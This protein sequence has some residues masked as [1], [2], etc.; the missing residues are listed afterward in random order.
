VYVGN[1]AMPAGGATGYFVELTF[2]SNH[3]SPVPLPFLSDPFVFTTEV[4]VKSPLP[5]HEWPFE[6]AFD[7]LSLG[8]AFAVAGSSAK[9]AATASALN[10][11]ASALA[12]EAGAIQDE[13]QP[14]APLAS[15]PVATSL[16]AALDDVSLLLESPTI[17]EAPADADHAIDLVLEELLPELLA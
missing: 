7:T 13:T 11:V 16:A 17:T 9:T 1:V 4:R 14:D 8:E 6:T 10:A 12:L 15:L 5:L 3:P 2:P